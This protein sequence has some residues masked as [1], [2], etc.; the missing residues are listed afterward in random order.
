MST[1]QEQ[2]TKPE[3]EGQ[4]ST[5]PSL[6]LEAATDATGTAQHGDAHRDE[7]AAQ[8]GPNDDS[9]E[10]ERTP[11]TEPTDVSTDPDGDEDDVDDDIDDET[12]TEQA[13]GATPAAVA[14]H[15]PAVPAPRAGWWSRAM[16]AN[17]TGL[18]SLIL[19]LCVLE[20]VLIWNIVQPFVIS[21]R[22]MALL[23]TLGVL[24]NVIAILLAVAASLLGLLGILRRDAPRAMAGIGLGI[25]FTTLWSTAMSMISY[26]IL[27]S[28]L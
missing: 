9:S 18:W 8:T 15:G 4:S 1:E 17:P 7:D 22:D 26:S 5:D 19:G 20:V 14:D 27:Q 11:P 13:T 12:Q 24:V 21:G 28:L 23:S 3:P 6:P 25:G 16:K 10:D 2:A